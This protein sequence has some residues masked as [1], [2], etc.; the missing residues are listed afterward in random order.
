MYRYKHV[1]PIVKWAGGKRQLLPEIKPLLPRRIPLYC[2][3]FFGGGAVFFSRQPRRAVI[4]DLNSDL[5]EMYRVVRDNPHELIESL[6]QHENSPEYFYRLRNLDR[7][8]EAFSAL[9]PVQKA[10]RLIYLNKTC[11]NGLFRVNASGEF[12]TPYGRYK[13]PN[14][15][16]KRVLCSVSRY[17]NHADIAL[18]SED[19]ESVLSRLPKG[20]FVYLDPPYDPV[21][22]TANFTGYQGGGFSRAEQIR[23]K[24]CCDDLNRR[25][26]RFL[27][28]NSATPFI[29]ELYQSYDITIVEAARA[30]NSVGLGRGAVREVLVK[31]YG[32]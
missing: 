20:A 31:N 18:S 30:I 2:E 17:L 28:S 29:L 10:S 32:I 7:D 8:R 26:I 5:M 9:S 19:F 24:N 23:L 1:A 16:N 27:L 6:K 22:D 3:P 13:N 21:S 4:N 25:G 14:I 12:N 11:F 15:I